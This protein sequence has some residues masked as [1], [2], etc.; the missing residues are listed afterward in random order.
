MS[1]KA[2]LVAL[3]RVQD[4][5][6]SGDNGP[7]YAHQLVFDNG[8]VGLLFS[9]KEVL[10]NATVNQEVEYDIE[11]KVNKRGP[12]KK[13]TIGGGARAKTGGKGSYGG[14]RDYKLE[15]YNAMLTMS[16]SYA[17]D[18]V[19][20]MDKP[21]EGDLLRWWGILYTQMKKIVDNEYDW[22]E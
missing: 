21:T 7:V 15:A 12:W 4:S 9:K 11:D 14:S 1:K 18:I 20:K 8:D 6:F 19:A 17:K 10:D 22:P 3:T 16:C 13:I 5:D 2:K